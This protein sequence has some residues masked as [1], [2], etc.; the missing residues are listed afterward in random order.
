MLRR[1][2]LAATSLLAAGALLL[3]AC[4]GEAAPDPDRDGQRPTPTRRR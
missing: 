3:T 1:T 2:T 4:T